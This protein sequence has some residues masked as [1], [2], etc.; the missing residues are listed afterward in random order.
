[1]GWKAPLQSMLDQ[2]EL[3]QDYL[4]PH[5]EAIEG[6]ATEF[7]RHIFLWCIEN[8]VALDGAAQ[9]GVHTAFY[10]DF[11]VHPERE[12]DRLF[13]FLKRDYRPAVFETL[14]QPSLLTLDEASKK[15]IRQGNTTCAA[16]RQKITPARQGR[17]LEILARFG[18]ADLYGE[19]GM[20]AVEAPA[21]IARTI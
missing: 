15:R 9:S 20:P 16:W 17:M 4:R 2:P 7:E 11:C 10:E 18:L 21:G 8:R 6:P 19:D 13:G 5:L 14:Q 1:M 12:I 3:I